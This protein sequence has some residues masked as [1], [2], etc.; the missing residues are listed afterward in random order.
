M[1]NSERFSGY[2]LSGN[3]QFWQSV[4]EAIPSHLAI[5]DESG[6]IVA[7]NHAWRDFASNNGADPTSVSEGVNYLTVCDKASGEGAED[8]KQAAAGIRAVLQGKQ[9]TFSLDYAC[10]APRKQ[11]WFKCHVSR[12]TNDNQPYVIVLHESITKRKRAV[13]NQA[14]YYNA[15]NASLNE[16][17]IFDADTLRFEFV[18]EGACRNLGY[19]LAELR[20]MTPLDIKPDYTPET[21]QSLIAPLRRKQR[22]NLTFKTRHRRANGSHY[23]VEVHLQ[24]FEQEERKVFIAVMLDLTDREQAEKALRDSEERYRLLFKNNPLPM[25]IYDQETLRFLE[26]NNTAVARYGY[27]RDEFLAM[28]LLDIRPE[29]ERE[30]LLKNVSAA[31]ETYQASG[32]WTHRKKD[33]QTIKVEIFS[34]GIEYAGRP[35]WCWQMT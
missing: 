15:L 19:S 17:Y 26:V 9:E 13:A 32:Y 30:R 29:D 28:T 25:W 10:H 34:H 18:S 12:F 33:G 7:V 16:I 35:G 14:F 4:L 5:L 6:M 11:R 31:Q 1:N 23:P 27:S 20:R 21:F 3:P 22:G 2:T 24:M 8:A